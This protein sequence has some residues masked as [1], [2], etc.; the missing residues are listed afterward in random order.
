MLG[1]LPTEET[2]QEPGTVVQR[3]ADLQGSKVLQFVGPTVL[4]EA[5]VVKTWLEYLRDG[6]CPDFG[7]ANTD[8]LTKVRG[9]MSFFCRL[10][11][12]D[13]EKVGK[14]VADLMLAQVTQLAS[15]GAPV[16]FKDIS[17]LQ[18]FKWLLS[19]EQQI[20]VDGWTA[21]A[22]RA[23]GNASDLKRTP[24]AGATARAQKAG[25]SVVDQYF[26]LQPKA[27][28]KTRGGGAAS[29]ASAAAAPK[30]A[31]KASK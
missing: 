24:K 2:A 30:R 9:V 31:A 20:I 29:S 18:K 1:Y 8:F 21:E 22:W 16:P 26:K 13:G 27:K 10:E 11:A 15:N 4:A 14:D 3:I 25:A 5:V 23:A 28:G 6:R 12:E 7:D 17:P 19:A